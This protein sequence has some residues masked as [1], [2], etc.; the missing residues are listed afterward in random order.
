[1]AAQQINLDTI[2]SNL[3]NVTT[4]GFKSQRAEFQ[5]LM[6]QTLRGAGAPTGTSTLQPTTIQIGLGTKF[7]SIGVNFSQGAME[8]TGNPT[9]LAISG[10]GYFRV[11]GPNGQTLYTRDGSFKTDA[12]GNMV[13]SDGYP[14][15]DGIQ[16]PLG[17]TAINVSADGLVS[18]V[19]P[20][21]TAPVEVGKIQLANFVNPSGLVHEGNNLLASSTASGEPQLATPGQNGTGT[22]QQNF[23]EGSNVS[24]VEEMVRM[25]TAQRAYEI[26][27]KAITTADDMLS[28]LNGL[29]R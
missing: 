28:T 5:D 20:G 17:A 12:N 7:A 1:M 13:T 4:V 24:V 22:L 16:I 23:L 2:A 25:I 10:S 11:N 26:N 15:T 3:A 8:Q 6:Y 27:S 18:V 29:K 21:S 14:L 9:D 19:P